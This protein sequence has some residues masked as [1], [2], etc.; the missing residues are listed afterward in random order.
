MAEVTKMKNGKLRVTKVYSAINCGRVVNQ[1]GAE[2][3]VEGAIIDGLSHALFSKVT[4]D[5]GAVEQK[6]FNTYKFLRMKHAP[7]EVIVKF[8]PSDDAPTGRANPACRQLHRQ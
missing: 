6:N 5:K 1:S 4:F 3:Q 8:V 2:T 7:L